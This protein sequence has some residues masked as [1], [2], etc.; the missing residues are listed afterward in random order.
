MLIISFS[1][2]STNHYVGTQNIACMAAPVQTVCRSMT[3][4]ARNLR[5]QRYVTT[6]Y[7]DENLLFTL[8]ANS[9]GKGYTN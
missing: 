2:W 8:H 4:T 1:A 6:D 7:I 9:V 5:N 3:V